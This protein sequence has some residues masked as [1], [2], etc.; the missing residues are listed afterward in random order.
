MSKKP[1]QRSKSLKC[2]LLSLNLFNGINIC[3]NYLNLMKYCYIEDFSHAN[4][5][6]PQM[7]TSVC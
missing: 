6:A 3:F 5:V 4:S 1:I 7:T 2:L